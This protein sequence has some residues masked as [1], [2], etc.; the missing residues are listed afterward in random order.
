[1]GEGR[2]QWM[3]QQPEEVVSRTVTGPED[4]L[5]V[6]EL[7]VA[8]ERLARYSEVAEIQRV[9]VFGPAEVVQLG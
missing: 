7:T 3:R 8:G 9:H 5:S 2:W 6:F 1:M 4:E